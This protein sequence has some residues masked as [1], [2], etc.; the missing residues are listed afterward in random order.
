MLRYGVAYQFQRTEDGPY[1]EPP[2][3]FP[4]D[5][6]KIKTYGRAIKVLVTTKITPGLLA[7]T[8]RPTNKLKSVRAA[9]GYDPCIEFMVLKV[10]G[11]DLENAMVCFERAKWLYQPYT[12]FGY[13]D[14]GG[15]AQVRVFA[16]KSDLP[17]DLIQVVPPP[18]HCDFIPNKYSLMAS[19]QL[20]KCVGC[21]H[22]APLGAD[23][24][25]G[26]CLLT[27]PPLPL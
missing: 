1:C 19:Q 3:L 11:Y 17:N 26:R 25:C 2:R 12:V 13:L 16:T 15:L 22:A 18:P 10:L 23:Q 14:N 5:A 20:N 27:T 9:A 6:S 21:Q 24:L 4:G 8:L 7:E